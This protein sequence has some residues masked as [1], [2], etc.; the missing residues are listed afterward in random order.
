M[1]QF[2]LEAFY[3]LFA[4]S[5]PV[6]VGDLQKNMNSLTGLVTCAQSILAPHPVTDG[7]PTT[8]VRNIWTE[9]LTFF[10]ISNM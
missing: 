10:F 5:P 6:C 3:V 4:C 7:P 9:G 1:V 8:S 2:Q